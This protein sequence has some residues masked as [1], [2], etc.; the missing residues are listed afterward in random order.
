MKEMGWRRPVSALLAVLLVLGCFPA[1][2]LAEDTAGLCAHH[3]AHTDCGY[4]EAAEGS[5]CAHVHDESCGYNEEAGTPCAH[6]HGEGCGYAEAVEAAPCGYICE[7]CAA[8]PT[9]PEETTEPSEPEETTESSEPAEPEVIAV[10]AWTWVGDEEVTGGELA[11]PGASAANVAYFE[12]IVSLLPYGVSTAQGELTVSWSCPGYPAEGAFEGSFD[13]TAMLPEG[14][15]LAEG[16]APLRVTVILGG[17]QLYDTVTGTHGDNLTWTFDTATGVLTVT[18]SGEMKDAGSKMYYPWYEYR[19]EITSIV[20]GEGITTVSRSAFSSAGEAQVTSL[21][22][23]S[24]LKSIGYDAFYRC[25][26]LKSVTL[27]AGLESIGGYA[28]GQCESLRTLTIPDSVTKIDSKAFVGCDMLQSVSVGKGLKDL[29]D[30]VFDNIDGLKTI[31]VSS[32]NPYFTAQDNVLY[33]K[34]MTELIAYPMCREGASF[35]VPSTVTKLHTSAFYKAFDLSSVTFTGAAPTFAADSFSNVTAEIRFDSAKSGWSTAAYRNYGGQL[36]WTDINKPNVI[37]GAVNDSIRWTLDLSTGAFTATGSGDMEYYDH[38]EGEYSPWYSYRTQITSVTVGSGI[39]S[40]GGSNFSGCTALTSV[41]LPAT[42]TRIGRSGFSGCSA[43]SSVS[44]PA[45]LTDIGIAAF[46]GCSKITS[47]TIPG[48]VRSIGDNAFSSTGLVSVT[49]PDSVYEVGDKAFAFCG[50]LKEV[51]FG[52]GT[53]VLGGSVFQQCKA[54]STL[55]FTGAMPSA[56]DNDICVQT[57]GVTAIYP[58]NAGWTESGMRDISTSVTWK[59]DCDHTSGTACTDN[60][61][62]LT[63]K[64]TCAN[65]GTVLA[66]KESHSYTYTADAA[67]RTITVG[68]ACDLRGVFT[69]KAP[70]SLLYTGAPVEATVTGSVEGLEAPAVT[71]TGP[72]TDGKPVEK[73]QYTATMTLGGKSVSITFTVIAPVASVTA[74]GVTT[75]YLTLGEALI[76]ANGAPGSILKLLSAQA[77]RETLTITGTDVTLDL[78]GFPLKN[79]SDDAIL[80]SSGAKLTVTDS[81]TNGSIYGYVS[82]GTFYGGAI[83]NEGTLVLQGGSLSADGT[84]TPCAV[85]NRGSFTMT[86]GT[87]KGKTSFSQGSGAA[88]FDGG[89]VAAKMAVDGGIVEFRSGDF[90]DI[91]SGG[92]IRGADVKITG[93]SFNSLPLSSPGATVEITGGTFYAQFDVGSSTTV[94]Y[95]GIFTR[96]IR[97][98]SASIFGLLAEGYAF[99]GENGDLMSPSYLTGTT[100]YLAVTVGRPN[101][102][103]DFEA[104]T[105]TG[106]KPGEGYTVNGQEVTAGSDGTIPIDPDWIGTDLTISFSG[107]SAAQTLQIPGRPGAPTGVEAVGETAYGKADGKLTGVTSAMEYRPEGGDWTAITGSEVTDLAPGTYEVRLGATDTA[108]AGTAA[109]FTVTAAPLTAGDLT[110]ILP[111]DPVYDGTP[112]LP[113]VTTPEGIDPARVRVLI[114]DEEDNILSSPVDAGT[115]RVFVDVAAEGDGDDLEGLTREDWTY[116]IAPARL[117]VALEPIGRQLFTGGECRPDMSFLWD[118][119][120]A[121]VTVKEGTDYTVALGQNDRPGTAT[122]T[123]VPVEGSNFTFEPVTASF[124]IC[125]GVPMEGYDSVYL[126]GSLRTVEEGILWLEEGEHGLITAYTHHNA[127]AEDPHLIYPTG[128]TVW[129]LDMDAEGLHRLTRESGLDDLL[130]YSGTSIRITGNQGIRFITSIPTSRRSALMGSGLDGY[131]LL[132]YGTLMGWYEPGKELLYGVSAKSVAYDRA[133]GTDAVFQSNGDTVQFTGML[134]DLELEQSDRDLMTRPYMVLETDDG[135]GGTVQLVLYGGSITRSIGYV[136]FQNKD[137]F[138]PGT[139]SYEFIW[140][141]LEYA[142]PDLY[143][144]EYQDK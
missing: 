76:A 96:G 126:N 30:Y 48:K 117:G 110:V 34:S 25:E 44:L 82:V 52:T 128:V 88:L 93:G 111:S 138:Q 62:G 63:H 127:G 15:A 6:S 106:L 13:F 123:V 133:T 68:C 75:D 65:C 57:S 134:T 125:R 73:G 36:T 89:T 23:P 58:A 144:Q 54:L 60:G 87:L 99:A 50:S 64:K 113:T 16:A 79:N 17:A 130:L 46:S 67:A 141:I 49:I 81:G 59:S 101:A 1:T 29:G 3:E 32:S 120:V 19:E 43:L 10:E 143:E 78:N 27:P 100:E 114:H 28:F 122:V 39:T 116:T 47:V 95:G 31:T 121:D 97:R 118:I 38:L 137:I 108:F 26:E 74:S 91:S 90:T 9:E 66:E 112:K 37:G 56:S 51:T 24:T 21:T 14:Y 104:E 83:V 55:T 33:N 139:D 131:R 61:D 132:E 42:V 69:L 4:R 2:V 140:S 71:Y 92:Y 5:P 70:A 85:I 80:V 35:T 94:L 12:D 45:G 72:T 109:T 22:L 84:N 86:G 115:Y 18:G 20:I 105:I 7:L 142:Y 136:A 41:S 129:R 11:L 135:A 103:V 102:S 119:P 40:V 124:E 53:R 8:E 107:Q 98:S 77:A